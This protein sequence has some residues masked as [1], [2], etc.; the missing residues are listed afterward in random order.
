LRFGVLYDFRNP[1]GSGLSMPDL[2][3]QV[4]DQIVALDEAGFDVAWFTEHHFVED[5]YLP[6]WVPVAG[7]VLA[8]TRR[9]RVAT[10]I[11][12]LP[13]YHPLRLAE[14]LAVLDN[15][16]GGRVEMGVGLGYAPHEFA[17]FGIPVSRRV[18][19]SEEALDILRL[20]WSGEPFSYR[21]K[22]Y[23]VDSVRVTPAPVQ[24]GGP[25]L[26]MGAMTEAGA[27]RAARYGLHFLPQGRRQVL[28]TWRQASRAGTVDVSE[29][30]AVTPRVGERRVGIIRPWLVTDDKER[31]WPA[32]REAERYRMQVY[33]RFFSEAGASFTIGSPDDIPQRWIIGD[34]AE[35]ETQLG[36]FIEELGLTDVMTHGVP[37]GLRPE[38]LTP[39]LE[40]FAR[41]VIP[42][43]RARFDT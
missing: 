17:G 41:E 7:A 33:A 2:Y 13:F 19:L 10:N 15:L 35:V 24:P 31:D 29:G 3:A 6:S 12:L 25:P 22:R 18:S 38:R 14:D 34:A 30:S 23:Q 40:R 11:A 5:G 9:M 43:L 39:S 4:L 42:R 8:R 26:W 37:P 32:I 27:Q 36:A 16:S 21:G 1:P 28:E 20:A